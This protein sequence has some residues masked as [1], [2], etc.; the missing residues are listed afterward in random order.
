MYEGQKMTWRSARE[1]MPCMTEEVVRRELALASRITTVTWRRLSAV[2]CGAQEA[3][4]YGTW[5]SV[6]E[7]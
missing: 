5:G 7:V 3:G 1:G 2:L 4:C 6:A